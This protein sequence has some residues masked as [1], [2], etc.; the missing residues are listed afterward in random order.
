MKQVRWD[1]AEGPSHIIRWQGV[2][3]VLDHAGRREGQ[4]AFAFATNVNK[5]TR[6]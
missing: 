6:P 4:D 3:L 5:G 2:R 1:L